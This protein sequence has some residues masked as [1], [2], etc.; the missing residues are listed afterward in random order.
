[1]IVL[2]G[3]FYWITSSIIIITTSILLEIG[4]YKLLNISL[5]GIKFNINFI[6]YIIVILINLILI[7]LVSYFNANKIKRTSIVDNISDLN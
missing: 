5:M 4:L 1:M 3:I 7:I 6:D 2:E